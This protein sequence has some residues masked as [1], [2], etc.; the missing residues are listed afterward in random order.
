[1]IVLDWEGFN[2]VNFIS[3][4]LSQVLLSEADNAIIFA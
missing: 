2:N 4:R 3:N 1:M